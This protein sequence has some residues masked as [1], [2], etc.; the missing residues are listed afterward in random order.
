MKR[1]TN[2]RIPFGLKGDKLV[3]VSEVESGLACGCICPSCSR[4]LQANKGKIITT[5]YFSHDPSDDVKPC[6]LAFET[7]IHRMSKQILSEEGSAIFPDLFISVTQSDMN[8]NVHLEESS[9]EDES[10]KYFEYV[11]LEKRIDKIRPDIIAYHQGTPFLIEI[12]VTNFTKA[13]KKSIIRNLELPAIEIDLS[14]I[15]YTIKKEELRELIINGSDNKKWLSNPK[16]ATVKTELQTKVA[17]KVRRANEDIYRNRSNKPKP[18]R[19]P[20]A[21][22]GKPTNY[23][24]PIAQVVKK[25]YDPRWFVCEA[26]RFIFKVPLKDAPYSIKTIPCPECDY[27]VSA[28]PYMA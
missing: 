23:S 13:Q 7:S 5:H 4:K 22:I 8:G 28:K 25:Q 17:E 16:A 19:K 24:K 26:C 2:N 15:D 21:P 10:K 6:S 1:T 9:V 11:D 20:V 18:V 14:S 3:Q 27:N 12:A